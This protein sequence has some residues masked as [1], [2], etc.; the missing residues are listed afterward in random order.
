MDKLETA[1]I[2]IPT[3]TPVLITTIHNG[4]FFGYVE[5]LDT[6][7]KIGKFSNMRCCLYWPDTNKGFLGLAVWGPKEGARISPAPAM[8]VITDL[9]SV[10][11][12]SP[13]AAAAW[14]AAPWSE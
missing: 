5:E 7:R 2:T 3:G 9:T 12:C 1:P 13:E 8:A 4:V 11:V 10:V 6:D 14:E